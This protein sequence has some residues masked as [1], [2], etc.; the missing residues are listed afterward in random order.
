MRCL[1]DK[2]TKLRLAIPLSLR[3]SRSKSARTSP[4]QCT[5]TV[6]QI[7]SKSPNRFTFGGVI[8]ERVDTV[9]TRC[10]VNPI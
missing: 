2:K 10:K 6:L 4:G 5:H 1:P 9:K 3:G 8:A 7:S